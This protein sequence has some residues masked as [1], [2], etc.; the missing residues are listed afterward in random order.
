[1]DKELE[2]CQFTT[3]GAERSLI[4]IHSKN[5]NQFLET[6][7]PSQGSCSFVEKEG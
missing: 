2:S 4:A 3:V 1:M 6:D 7:L 5:I